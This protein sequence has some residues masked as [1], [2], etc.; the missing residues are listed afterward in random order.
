METL[1]PIRI[2]YAEDHTIVRK[3]VI[4][5]L[6]SLGGIVVDIEAENGKELISKIEMTGQLPDVCVLD[7][8]MPV[9]NGFETLI[10]LKK[11]WPEIKTLVLTLYH[12]DLYIIKMIRNGANGYLVKRCSP[13]EIKKA[14]QSICNNGYYYSEVANHQYFKLVNNKV[15][16]LPNFTPKEIEVLRYSCTDLSYAE[17]GEK[18]K[19]TQRSVEGIR[20]SLFKKLDVHSRSSLVICAIKYGIVTIDRNFSFIL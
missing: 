17:I 6:E 4:A 20:D 19:T 5:L 18:M 15:I 8:D 13:H 14:L 9:M 11:K 3:G 2:A 10:Y 7:I 16:R 1:S 12:E